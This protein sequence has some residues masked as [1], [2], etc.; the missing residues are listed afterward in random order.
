ME[1]PENRFPL[2]SEPC[3]TFFVLEL[4]LNL[5]EILPFLIAFILGMIAQKSN[6]MS[7]GIML[8][9]FATYWVST[10]YWMA[11]FEYGRAAGV[12]QIAIEKALLHIEFWALGFAFLGGV[13]LSVARRR[14]AASRA[15]DEATNCKINQG[16]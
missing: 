12:R 1:I 13:A 7:M 4:P 8:I 15:F 2:P 5:I 16:D 6:V 11:W 9:T 10:Q 14:V 3:F